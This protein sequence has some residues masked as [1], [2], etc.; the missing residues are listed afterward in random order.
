MNTFLVPNN[1]YNEC[2]ACGQ[3]NPIGLHLIFYQKE[4]VVYTETFIKQEFAGWS[5]LTHGGIL[6]TIADETMAW[7]AIH[8]TR[9]YMLTKDIQIQFLRPCTVNQK[10]LSEGR[11]IEWINPREVVIEVQIFLENGKPCVKSKG[12]LVL[13][14][15][16][17]LRKKNLF[18]EDYLKDFENYVPIED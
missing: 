16:S 12:N 10:V 15:K 7:T 8:L 4:N 18:D 13:F 11:I 3:K 2:F 9:R 14:T 1:P 6:T 17:E 5:N